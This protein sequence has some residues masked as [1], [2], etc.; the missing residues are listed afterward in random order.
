MTAHPRPGPRTTLASSNQIQL[1]LR[2]HPKSRVL[3]SWEKL[4]RNEEE[5]WEKKM[6]HAVAPYPDLE[7]TMPRAVIPCPADLKTNKLDADITI[8]L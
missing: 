2:F 3:L 5:A 4:R 7:E 6:P 8:Q 1:R